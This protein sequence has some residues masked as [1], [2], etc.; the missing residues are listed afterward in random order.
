M[1][2]AHRTEESQL[3]DGENFFWTLA[4]HLLARQEVTRSTMMG[5]PCLRVGGAFFA[6]C[7]RK[8][9][10]LLVKLSAA[11]V[12]ELISTGQAE[13]FAPA[14]R[15]FREWAAVPFAKRR[16]WKPL[17]QESLAFVEGRS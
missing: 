9:D 17:L 16:A 1:A 12:A 8:T 14:G 2:D 10:D 6:S 13:P 4:Q 15:Q 11:R 5:L 3:G 7:D